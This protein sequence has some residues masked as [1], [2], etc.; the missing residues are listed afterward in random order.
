MSEIPTVDW[1]EKLAAR[2][3]EVHSNTT[4]EERIARRASK[5]LRSEAL[6]Q[7][8]IGTQ[9]KASASN[10][11]PSVSTRDSAAA[12]VKRANIKRVGFRERL[13][14]LSTSIH[15]SLQSLPQV[16][17]K[18]YPSQA[19]GASLKKRRWDEVSLQPRKRDYGG[20]GLARPSLFLPFED[21]SFAPK[22]EEE[23]VEHIPGFF[24][25]QKTKV[26]KKKSNQ[27]MLWKKISETKNSDEKLNGKK[28]SNMTPNERVEAFIAAG[29][30]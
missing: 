11:T 4:K 15:T 12:N 28:I 5:R 10:K 13:N 24:G 9:W 18:L 23:F 21:L 27:R 26:M 22:L 7:G 17:P 6:K 29:L 20:I 16:G 3:S 14:Y 1:I 30:L 2:V 19:Q 25:K 8:A